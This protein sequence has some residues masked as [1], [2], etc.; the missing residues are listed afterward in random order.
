MTR[1]V[2]ITGAVGG[3]GKAFSAECAARGWN[4]FLTDLEDELLAPLAL[5]LSRLYGVG[6]GHL[7]CDLTDAAERRALWEHVQKQG[8]Q[9][10]MLINIA[11]V[12]FEGPFCEREVDELRTMLRL[13]I[14]AVVEMTR[15]VM[16]HRNPVQDLRIINVSSMAGFY[17]MPTKAV[18]SASKRF[19]IDFSQ[20]LNRELR[21][22]GATV[23]V[24]CPAGLP[25][26]EVAIQRIESQGFLGR[27]TTVNVGRMV[28][29]TI[30][31][32]LKGRAIYIPGFVN[33]VLR[34]LCAL[35]PA[36]MVISLIGKRWEKRRKMMKTQQSSG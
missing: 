24:L 1:T 15:V 30:D 13:N 10:D 29:H 3:L 16:D 6:V 26:R 8:L 14:E 27:L 34:L 33:H 2:C 7:D 28:S 20:A 35:L 5:G 23:T 25:T 19:L 12:E 11:G 17:P 18:Y 9:F 22:N 36:S 31:L 21:P 4:L 32:A